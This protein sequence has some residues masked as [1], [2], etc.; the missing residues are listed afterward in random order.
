MDAFE[1][2]LNL[3]PEFTLAYVHI[4]NIYQRKRMDNRAIRVANR[5]IN[6]NPEKSSGYHYLAAIYGWMG[7]LDKSIMNYEKAAE[8][9]KGNYESVVLQGWAYRIGGNYEAALNKYAELFEPDVP[10]IWQF[11]GKMISS[12]V[13]AEQGQYKK[14]IQLTREAI[15]IGRPFSEQ[16]V[17]RSMISLAYNY[18]CIADTVRAFSLLDSVLDMNPDMDWERQTY[19]VKGI[20]YAG[21]GNQEEVRKLID[22]LNM[23]KKQIGVTFSWDMPNI[24]K[25]KLFRL[26][27]NTE[28]VMVEYNKLSQFS[29]L[30]NLDFKASLYGDAR[31][32][33]NV[34]LTADEMQSSFLFGS[35]LADF[36]RKNYP[37]SFYIRG[38]AYEELGKPQLAIE[39]YEAL[40]DLWK[41]ADKEIP[42]RRDAIKR[43]TTLKKSS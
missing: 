12:F 31:D 19:L 7:E 28:K 35:I 21:S 2:A 36:R 34:I 30:F 24:L 3:D 11:R 16:N 10:A 14:A 15:R 27:G 43:L 25:M 13:Y 5:L 23:P 18:S 8:L 38:K 26:R 22:I 37:R 39:N 33:E 42:E 29:R 17:I 20:L 9:N 4:F 1:E 40:L 41:D 32:W 6:S